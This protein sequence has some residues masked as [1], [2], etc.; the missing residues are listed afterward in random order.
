MS[1]NFHCIFEEQNQLIH[2]DFAETEGVSFPVEFA[3]TEGLLFPVEFCEIHELIPN[4]VEEY[5]GGYSVTPRVDEQLLCTAKKF[6]VEDVTIKAIPFYNVSNNSGGNTVYI[7]KE[8][9]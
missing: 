6:M 9:E 1:L 8:I 3:E 7:G 4:G 5:N 2:V